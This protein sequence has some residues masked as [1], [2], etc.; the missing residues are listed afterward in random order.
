MLK[1]TCFLEI[2]T[3]ITRHFHNYI[4]PHVITVQ[5]HI[6]D[7]IS[8]IFFIHVSRNNTFS[9]GL[10]ERHSQYIAV[11]SKLYSWNRMVMQNFINDSATKCE[12][13]EQTF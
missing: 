10:I 4:S 3:Q 13:Y 9:K 6:L 11:F 8:N 1:C 12:M 5:P 7:H 2:Q